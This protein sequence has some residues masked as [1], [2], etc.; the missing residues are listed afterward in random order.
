VRLP[1]VEIKFS[2]L[3]FSINYKLKKLKFCCKIAEKSK[4]V[5]F[6]AKI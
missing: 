1:R 6:A 5:T 4:N 2:T 3:C